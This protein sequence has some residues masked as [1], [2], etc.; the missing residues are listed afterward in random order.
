MNKLL[1]RITTFFVTIYLSTAAMAQDGV[2]QDLETLMSWVQGS[3]SNQAQIDDGVLDAESNLLFPVFKHVDIPAF[4]NHVIYLQ[5]PIGAPDGRLQRQRIWSFARGPNGLTMEFFTL[6]E[7]GRWLDAHIN[8]KKVRDMNRDDVIA[9]PETCLLPVVWEGEAFV[10]RIPSSC[11]IVSQ[12]TKITM[13]L[14]A[15]TRIMKGKVTYGE[16]GYQPD[17]T[18]VFKVPSEARYEFDKLEN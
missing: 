10:M 18:R 6:K 8:P 11:V 5:W 9:Y 15:E 16:G 13:T 12:G 14:E 7:P 4:G 3:Y 17:G 2:D 1:A